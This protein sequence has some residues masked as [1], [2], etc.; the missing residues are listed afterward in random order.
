MTGDC[1]PPGNM[2]PLLLI[3][4][5]ALASDGQF[6]T[7]M[8]SCTSSEL[9]RDWTMQDAGSLW[10]SSMGSRNRNIRADFGC[11]GQFR[12][13]GGGRG[14]GQGSSP[15]AAM[16]CN[17]RTP[18]PAV[19]SQQAGHGGIVTFWPLVRRL[20]CVFAFQCHSQLHSLQL[21]KCQNRRDFAARATASIRR[22]GG[23]LPWP[24]VS[25]DLKSRKSV[26]GEAMSKYDCLHH[27]PV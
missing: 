22:Y 4:P 1:A 5:L 15:C 23:L 6:W 17:S 16:G 14:W 7:C 13:G 27:H 9:I 8:T 18:D 12:G 21:D 24:W 3:P 10:P 25:Y 11:G 19:G 26:M 2:G 20:V